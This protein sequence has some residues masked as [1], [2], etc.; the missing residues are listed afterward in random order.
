M[1]KL[2]I[3]HE[4]MDPALQ[5]LIHA[6]HDKWRQNISEAR[7]EPG[8]TVAAVAHFLCLAIMSFCE[9]EK[10]AHEL[11]NTVMEHSHIFINDNWKLA[12]EMVRAGDLRRA[13]GK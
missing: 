4:Q 7:L 8:H 3:P 9:T 1:G 2:N 6:I 12:Q 11:F 13:Q 5:E 10:Q